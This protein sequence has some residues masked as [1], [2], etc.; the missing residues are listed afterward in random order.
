MDARFASMMLCLRYDNE[1]L[2]NHYRNWLNRVSR[3][4]AHDFALRHK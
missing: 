2:F 1:S 3:S 4:I